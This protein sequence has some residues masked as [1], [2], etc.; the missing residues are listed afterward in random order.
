[1][2]PEN[3]LF[4]K[5]NQIF[6]NLPN[7]EILAASEFKLAWQ[8][9]DNPPWMKMYFLLKN[10]DVPMS[11]PFSKNVDDTATIPNSWPGFGESVGLITFL[12]WLGV[13]VLQGVS[14]VRIYG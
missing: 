2:E 8:A 14:K 1:M 6:I 3:H 11:Y 13:R 5:E 4:E 10:G 7:L 9:M 12:H